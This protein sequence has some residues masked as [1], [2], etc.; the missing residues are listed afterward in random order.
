MVICRTAENGWKWKDLPIH[1]IDNTIFF[2]LG[3]ELMEGG[4]R[5]FARNIADLGLPITHWDERIGSVYL[6]GGD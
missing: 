2:D 4:Y 3:R 5:A 1:M 6:A